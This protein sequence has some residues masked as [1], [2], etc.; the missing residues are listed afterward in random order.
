M[1][2]SLVIYLGF[3]ATTILGIF[4]GHQTSFELATPRIWNYE[5]VLF[6]CTGIPFLF[7]IPYAKIPEFWETTI[8]L[9][10]K[11]W[12]PVLIGLAFGFADLLIVEY[13]LDHPPHKV[14]PPYTQP[15]PYSLF[16]FFSGAFEIEVFYRLIP[17][18]LVLFIARRYANEKAIPPIFWGIALLTSL[19]EPL[20]QFPSGPNWFIIYALLSGFAM[21]LMQAIYLKKSGFV[22]AL[23][24]RQSHY[25]IWHILNG[26]VIEF[27]LLKTTS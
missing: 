15:F 17:I 1:N 25:L 21:N 18:T 10:N 22:S 7:L 27:F 24:I 3:F 9:K 16:L 4:I 11:V 19:R 13:G 14:L 12:M 26:V 2:R 23:L 5:N 6:M 8:P 20:E